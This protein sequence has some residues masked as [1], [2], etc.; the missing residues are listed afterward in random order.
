MFELILQVEELFE[1][2][3]QLVNCFYLRQKKH[4]SSGSGAMKQE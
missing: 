4:K 3:L 1:L 2:L